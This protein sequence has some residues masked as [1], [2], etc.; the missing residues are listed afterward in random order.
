VHF[1]VSGIYSIDSS[2]RTSKTNAFFTGL[3][4]NRRIALFD[5]LVAKHPVEEVVAVLAHEIGHY[6]KKHTL[7]G[8]ILSTLQTGIMMFILSLFIRKDSFIAQALCQALSGFSGIPV[9]QS[10]HAG[11]LA[12][13]LLYSP[14]SFLLGLMMNLISRKNEYAADRF[15]GI[16]HSPSSLMNALKKLSVNNLSNLRP[17]PAY[18]FFYYSHP[19]LLQRLDALKKIGNAESVPG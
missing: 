12:F 3:G 13:G 18:V 9:K 10:F 7:T 11:I 4:K 15:A 6:K 5:T 19:P 8:I 2:R 1:P 14:L 17:H 16:H